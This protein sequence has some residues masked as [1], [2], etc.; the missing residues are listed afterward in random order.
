MEDGE[1]YTASPD[2]KVNV[3]A[4]D[5]VLRGKPMTTGIIPFTDVVE[6]RGIVAGRRALTE[7]FRETLSANGTTLSHRV[8]DLIGRAAANYVTVY[9]DLGDIAA[10]DTVQYS[11][12]KHEL[13]KI[14]V[15]KQLK[16]IEEGMQLAEEFGDLSAGTILTKN[17][18]EMIRNTKK[19]P[20]TGKT[21]I[22]ITPKRIPLEWVAKTIY[23]AGLA[24]DDWMHH[25]G[26]R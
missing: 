8:L 15:Q 24:D 11:T 13:D 19:M 17:E 2:V 5:S 26:A 3:K 1:S 9:V 18:A 21:F 6:S 16:N 25:I 14:G 4:G 22:K 23:T 10:G 12:L 20:N 7:Q